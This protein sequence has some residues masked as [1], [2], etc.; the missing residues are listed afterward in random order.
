[1]KGVFVLIL[2][3]AVLAGCGPSDKRPALDDERTA[4]K[5]GLT[6]LTVYE[7]EA[8]CSSPN[9]EAAVMSVSRLQHLLRLYD[10]REDEA[11][12]TP[13]I[14]YHQV[15]SMKIAAVALTKAC[16]LPA[17]YFYRKIIAVYPGAAF[18]ELRRQANLGLQAVMD[19][20][21]AH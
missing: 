9:L 6:A 2:M 5:K 10:H 19:S 4:Y 3:S 20:R 12:L 13:T 11:R 17:E 15:L 14:R 7:Q 1:M 21:D 18:A 8:S 16:F